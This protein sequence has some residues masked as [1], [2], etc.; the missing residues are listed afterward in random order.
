MESNDARWSSDD[1]RDSVGGV[2]P[3]RAFNA[4]SF[5]CV[6]STLS[7][8][9][10]GDP[11]GDASPWPIVASFGVLSDSEDSGPTWYCESSSSAPVLIRRFFI[12]SR[13]CI[14]RAAT[15]GALTSPLSHPARDPP[16][17]LLPLCDAGVLFPLP[18]AR[19][20]LAAFA[21]AARRFNAL[22]SPA[23]PLTRGVPRRLPSGLTSTLLV[24]VPIDGIAPPATPD[25]D[26]PTPG[27]SAIDSTLPP[28]CF[29]SDA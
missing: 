12:P 13:A 2:R 27:R 15:L 6:E 19:T 9:R 16:D 26:E 14:L 18:F 29:R 1:V 7:G 23:F 4:E 28:R 17:A 21:A 5:P 8:R 20:F 3:R 10:D 24:D 22:P 25:G 11:T